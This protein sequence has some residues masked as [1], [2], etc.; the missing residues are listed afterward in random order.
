[1][2]ATENLVDR[3]FLVLQTRHGRRVRV[4]AAADNGHRQF[5]LRLLRVA[6]LLLCPDGAPLYVVELLFTSR[7]RNMVIVPAQRRGALDA[8]DRH[9]ACKLLIL[10][11]I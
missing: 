2:F 6:R 10:F 1:M 11:F 5:L 4:I 9:K 3:F 8:L 7:D